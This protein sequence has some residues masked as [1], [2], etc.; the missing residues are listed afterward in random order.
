MDN[1]GSS[2]IHFSFLFDNTHPVVILLKK[3]IEEVFEAV[4]FTHTF[5]HAFRHG[6][7]KFVMSYLQAQDKESLVDIIAALLE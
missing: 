2:L 7:G 6:E 3:D 5:E 4:L 1:T